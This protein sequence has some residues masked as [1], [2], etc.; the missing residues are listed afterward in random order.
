MSV[1]VFI[2]LVA[3]DATQN[4]PRCHKAFIK[5]TGIYGETKGAHQTSPTKGTDP[6]NLKKIADALGVPPEELA[7]DITAATVDRQNPEF[8]MTV[9]AG[10][11]DK[12]HLKVNKL[13]PWSIATMVSQLLD[14]AN[15]LN[16]GLADPHDP[17]QLHLPAPPRIQKL[18]EQ[19]T[20]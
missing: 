13:V 5:E 2:C 8:A 20:S 10:H 9:V 16:S 17:P 12:C 19:F 6:H 15:L 7:P 18:C 1:H 4:V 3:Y 14:Y 11:S